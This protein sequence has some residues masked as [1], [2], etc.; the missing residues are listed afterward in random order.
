VAALAAGLSAGG[1]FLS[2]QLFHN[3]QM[4]Y[5]PIRMARRLL[6]SVD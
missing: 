5:C 6:I 3:P 2:A 4:N 1:T